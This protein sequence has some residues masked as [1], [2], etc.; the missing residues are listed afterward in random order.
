MTTQDTHVRDAVRERY[1]RAAEQAATEASCCGPSDS[2]CCGDSIYDVSETEALPETVTNASLGCGNPTALDTLQAGDVVLDLGSG[3]G[4]DVFLAAQRVGD[5]GRAIGLDMTPEMIALARENA[6]KVGATNAEFIKG[7]IEDIPLPDESV[8]VIISNCVINLSTDKEQVFR[9][10]YRVLRP[11]G[12]LLVSDIVSDRPL[13]AS[14][15]ANVEFWSACVGGAWDEARYL[16]AVQAA[17]FESVDVVSRTPYPVPDVGDMVRLF[18]LNF[19]AR[20]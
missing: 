5:T 18:S 1:A 20:K 7:E 10:A 11:G 9:E 2:S 14:V 12:R 3:G 6:K 13:P 15:Q 16:D 17:G 8:D 4:I 19:R